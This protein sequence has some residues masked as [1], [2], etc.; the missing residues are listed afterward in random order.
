MVW[1]RRRIRDAEAKDKA[2]AETK[3]VLAPG[4]IHVR[5]DEV[6]HEIVDLSEAPRDVLVQYHIDAATC[7]KRKCILATVAG[8]REPAMSATKQKFRERHKVIKLAQIQTRTEQ[9]ARD[10]ARD[11]VAIDVAIEMIAAQLRGQ[12]EKAVCV[13]S[14]TASRAVAIEVAEPTARV[15]VDVAVA[16]VVF[17]ACGPGNGVALGTAGRAK[18]PRAAGTAL[19]GAAGASTVV[20][21]SVAGFAALSSFSSATSGIARNTPTAAAAHHLRINVLPKFVMETFRSFPH[22]PLRTSCAQSG[23]ARLKP[24]LVAQGR[25]AQLPTRA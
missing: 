14:E 5:T 6:R 21:V 11:L 10:S 23:A 4:G 1:R 19:S 16:C 25:P 17:V 20:V 22:P 9:V 15:K 12:P 7:S 8:Q 18:T 2:C 24:C 3:I 13:I